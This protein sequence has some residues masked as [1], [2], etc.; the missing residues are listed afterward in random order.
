MK[1]K[2]KMSSYHTLVLHMAMTGNLNDLKP[3]Q[4]HNTDS[5]ENQEW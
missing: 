2:N 5:F 4:S 3:K 1:V